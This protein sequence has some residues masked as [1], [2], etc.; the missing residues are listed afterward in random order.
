MFF[1][2][3]FI[4]NYVYVCGELGDVCACECEYWYVWKPEEGVRFREVE[5]S[6]LDSGN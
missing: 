5:P 2:Y 3:V 1:A 4:F 6:I